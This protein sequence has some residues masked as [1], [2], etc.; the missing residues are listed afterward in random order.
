MT[1]RDHEQ[2]RRQGRGPSMGFLIAIGCVLS[3]VGVYGLLAYGGCEDVGS[4]CHPS[5]SRLGAV[6]L[7]LAVCVFGLAFSRH[8]SGSDQ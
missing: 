1:D 4:E 7:I 6:A 3:I 8:R 2:K 5:L